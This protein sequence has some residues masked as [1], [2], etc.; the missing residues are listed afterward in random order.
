MR[1]GRVPWLGLWAV[2]AAC[3]AFGCAGRSRF[4]PSPAEIRLV[5][6]MAQRLEM[7]REVAWIKF[8]NNAPVKD[9]K[10]ESELL[11]SLVAQGTQAGIPAAEVESFFQAQIRASRQVQSGLIFGW[12]RG[13]TLP[14]IPPRDLRRDIRPQLDRI[15]AELLRE[16]AAGTG[17]GANPAL[18]GYA[19]SVLRSRGFS[20]YVARIAADPLR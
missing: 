5:E 12:R 18:A 11:V 16:L 13:R 1:Y 4:S 9:R 10:R 2:L 8:E 3:L 17:R 20:W 15:S 6:L 19:E 7:A 14:A